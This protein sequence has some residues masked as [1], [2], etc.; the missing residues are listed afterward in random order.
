MVLEEII[1]Q[2]EQLEKIDPDAVRDQSE[3]W[4]RRA[5]VCLVVAQI[6]LGIL[7]IL[8]FTQFLG[9]H[10]G[11]SVPVNTDKTTGGWESGN[12][13]A[14]VIITIFGSL[15]LMV[16][17]LIVNDPA[18][19]PQRFTRSYKEAVIA[20]GYALGIVAFG[21]LGCAFLD[22][23]AVVDAPGC[24]GGC[25]RGEYI[26]TCM[27]DMF[28]FIAVGVASMAMSSFGQH[29]PSKLAD[30]DVQAEA[31]IKATAKAHRLELPQDAVTVVAVVAPCCNSLVP[32]P[33]LESHKVKCLEHKRVEEEKKKAEKEERKKARAALKRHEVMGS[34]EKIEVRLS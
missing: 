21:C 29:T 26:A 32:L 10:R 31:L 6:V 22:V 27:F 18:N 9:A 25:D 17:M 7:G 28:A 4:R 23:S 16:C 24:K 20:C 2:V 14:H 19:F 1:T 30:K 13:V 11:A 5:F 15:V 12:D 33:E 8:S 34:D 3:P